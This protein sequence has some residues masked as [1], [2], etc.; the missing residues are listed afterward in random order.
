MTGSYI[1][2]IKA[3]TMKKTVF[4]LTLLTIL[5]FM[6]KAQSPLNSNPD[7]V[8]G[9]FLVPDDGN[10]SKV[11]FTKN[12]DGT[13]DCTIIWM[14][15]PIDPSTGKPWLDMQNPDKSQRGKPCLGLQIIKGLKY[16]SEKK[17]WGGT[18]VYDSNRG[19]KANVRIVF[20]SDGRLCL[21]GAILGIGKTAYWVRSQR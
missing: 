4:I 13:Y 21:K 7:S 2:C 14:E 19:I 12:A 10:D 18:K 1:R 20:S 8:L 17:R 11:E 16:D 5:P 15:N 6:V 9:I 3:A